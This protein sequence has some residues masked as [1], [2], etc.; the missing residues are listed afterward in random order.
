MCHSS[1]GFSV[2]VAKSVKKVGHIEVGSLRDK[3]EVECVFIGL[4]HGLFIRAS[5]TVFATACGRSSV[6]R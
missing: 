3:A 6:V 2:D 4:W 1:Y 5:H